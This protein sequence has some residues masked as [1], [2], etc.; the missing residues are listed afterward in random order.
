MRC[1]ND[2]W[3]AWRLCRMPCS[4]AIACLAGH[5]VYALFLDGI[6]F[7]SQRGARDAAIWSPD[8]PSSASQHYLTT[9]DPPFALAL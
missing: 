1:C 8:P 2:P 5:A 3:L 4:A 6:A 7:A 9:A